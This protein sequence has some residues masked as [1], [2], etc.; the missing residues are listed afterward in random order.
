MSN[1]LKVSIIMPVY[2]GAKYIV[3][4][5]ESV[6]NQTYSNWELVVIDDCSSDN[7]LS[8]VQ[9]FQHIHNDKVTILSSGKSRSNAAVCRNIG[10]RNAKGDYVIFLD[11]DDTLAPFCLEQRMNI[12]Q[13]NEAFLWGI[14]KQYSLN[15][16]NA[17]MTVY[18]KHVDTFDNAINCF[19]EMDSPWTVT[20]P[21]WKKTFLTDLKGFNELFVFMEDPELHVRALFKEKMLPFVS[22]KEPPDCYYRKGNMDEEKRE[23]FHKHSIESRVKFIEF[24]FSVHD[25]ISQYF[26]FLSKGFKVFF[27]TLVIARISEYEECIRPVIVLL[28][29]KKVLTKFDCLKINAVIYIYKQQ[30]FMVRLLRLKGLA[31]WML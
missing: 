15:P 27:K 2:N 30:G 14:F 31:Y 4:A 6:E 9:H 1:G 16:L 10:L 29:S 3:E 5:L 26:P 21:I 17:P 11:A 13:A 18:N 7:S 12:M 19:F 22:T 8:I 23:T 20:C 28:R 24:I 25:N